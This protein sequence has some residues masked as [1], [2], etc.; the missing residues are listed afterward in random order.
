MRVPSTP[1]TSTR[2]NTDQAVRR[3]IENFSSA[4]VEAG[5]PQMPALVFVALLAT[6]DSGLTGD[7]L[8]EQLQVSRAAISGAVN[9]LAPLGLITRERQPGSRRYRY[10]LRDPTWFE[11]VV[12]RERILD[13]WITTTREG[14]DALGLATPAGQRLAESLA[15]FEFL[16]REMPAMLSRWRDQRA[17]NTPRN[18]T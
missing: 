14:I 16:Q 9:Y 2:A 3:F 1:L 5:L 6:D 7:E 11:L 17:G 10:V 13:R 18:S 12:R 8:T 4:L 15:F